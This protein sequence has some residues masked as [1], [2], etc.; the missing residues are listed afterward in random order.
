M[1]RPQHYEF[2]QYILAEEIG[3]DPASAWA[4]LTDPVI[5]P[6]VLQE[7]WELAHVYSGTP[8]A[9][10]PASG[11]RAEATQVG[12]WP[13]VL[14]TLPTPIEPTEAWLALVVLPDVGPPRCLL[15]EA[16]AGAPLP[17]SIPTDWPDPTTLTATLICERPADSA[18]HHC[19]GAGP[20]AFTPQTIPGFIAGVADVLA[21]AS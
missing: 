19:Y 8:A 6:L 14:I 10:L 16:A 18:T 17:E 9:P 4:D 21:R 20:A 12:P 7:W 15:L 1:A 11:L 5:A 2:A 3:L 13:A